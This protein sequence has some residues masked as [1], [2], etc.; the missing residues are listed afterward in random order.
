MVRFVSE[1][2]GSSFPILFHLFPLFK[3]AIYVKTAIYLV[4]SKSSKPLSSDSSPES[5]NS[6]PPSQVTHA[7][8]ACCFRCFF[9]SA[10]TSYTI[11]LASKM[12]KRGQDERAK[13]KKVSRGGNG[14]TQTIELL[15]R[16]QACIPK[17]P[18]YTCVDLRS[19]P[20]ASVKWC[21]Q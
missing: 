14:W 4:W 3:V 21:D 9:K 19:L 10:A 20:P 1:C 17:A 12:L 18:G 8:E 11:S 16:S 6:S 7:S 13:Q 2:L 15:P 5:Q